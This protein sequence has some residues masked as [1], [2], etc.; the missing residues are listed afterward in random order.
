MVLRPVG[1][2][3]SFNTQNPKKRRCRFGSPRH[4]ATTKIRGRQKA[5]LLF[6]SKCGDSNS[7]PLGPK[8]SAL[9]GELHLEILKFLVILGCLLWTPSCGARFCQRSLSITQNR[10][11]RQPL[12][13]VSATGGARRSPLAVPEILFSRYRS[14]NFDRGANPCSLYPPQAALAGVAQTKRST[15]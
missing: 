2:C 8:P 5:Y 10:P 6:W 14:Q 12:L 9:P 4:T 15:G 3:R 11:R 7:V 13:A 1:A